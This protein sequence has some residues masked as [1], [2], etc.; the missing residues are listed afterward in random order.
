MKLSVII[1]VYNEAKTV[2]E[3]LRRAAAQD[4]GAW[5]KEII[6]VDDGSTDGSR[7]VVRAAKSQGA[8]QHCTVVLHEKNQGKGMAIRTALRYATGEYVLIQ[9]ADLE[10][11]PAD[12]PVLLRAAEQHPEAA[13]YGSRRLSPR[14]RRYWRSV[15]GVWA[16]TKLVNILC[17]SRLTDVYTGYK[18]IPSRAVK[19]LGLASG[20][21]EFEA[22]LTVKLLKNQIPIIEVPIR[23]Y[24]RTFS[25]GKKIRWRDGLTG[26][27]TVLKIRFG[28]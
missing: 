16:L 19:G 21:F 10:Y 14:H 27:W 12:W 8:I 17:G 20:G 15:F 23:Y 5:E 3:I 24:P 26:L 18:L 22:E 1:P 9:D 6:V 11:D 13:I 4:I 25:D 7:D 28:K 2:E